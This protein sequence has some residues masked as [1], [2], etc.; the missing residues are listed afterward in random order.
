MKQPTRPLI[1][2]LLSLAVCMIA[3]GAFFVIRSKRPT[4]ALERELVKKLSFS[5]ESSLNIWNEKVLAKHET[6]Y[7]LA[8]V[9]GKHCVKAVSE[10]SAST[11][12]YRQRLL[13]DRNPFVGWEWKVESFPG[14]KS[15]ETLK[16]K[17]EF[18]FAAQFY[19]VFYSRFFLK[20]KAIQYVWTESLP[21]GT[22]G[23]SPYT[24]NVMIMV[25]E[26]GESSSWK[27]E[28]RDIREDFRQLFGYELEK[29]IEAVSFMTDSDSTESGAVAYFGDIKLGYLE[30][31]PDNAGGKQERKEASSDI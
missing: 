19:V 6:E 31:V 29:N 28:E 16:G 20:M 25:L 26:P 27:Y 21:V 9:D 17:E 23:P 11:L 8:E 14:R 4:G 18:D 22:V 15:K 7:S 1:I 30:A 12:F 13:F 5:S 3:G 10:N 24:K 2:V